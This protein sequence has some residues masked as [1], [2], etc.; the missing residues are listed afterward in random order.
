VTLFAAM[1]PAIPVRMKISKFLNAIDKW[2]MTD[3]LVAAV[4][5]A[6]FTIES[7]KATQVIPCRGLYYFAGYALIS[8]FTTSLLVELNS[9]EKSV[10]DASWGLLKIPY[11]GKLFGVLLFVSAILAL[12]K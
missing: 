2:S 6:C 8:M 10:A 11:W 4:I 9:E 5:L 7:G 12:K 1:T 3:V